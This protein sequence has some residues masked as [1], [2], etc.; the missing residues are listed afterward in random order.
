MSDKIVAG[1]N[2]FS[3]N[4]EPVVASKET[5]RTFIKEMDK[6][7]SVIK[8]SQDDLKE[9]ISTH[10]EIIAIDEQ[11]KTL[12]EERKNVIAESAVIQ[13]YLARLN[14]LLEE[15]KQIIDD[16]KQDGVPKGEVDL[17]IKAL[18]KGLN[19]NVSTDI[20]KNIA[21]LID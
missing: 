13:G 11:I 16:A 21:D 10:D 12:K 15:R 2:P 9:A 18:K 5:I 4:A 17:A 6:I 20:Y 19:M 1:I 7:A 14:E 8:E 3:Q